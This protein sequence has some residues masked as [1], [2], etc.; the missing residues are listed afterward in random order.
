MVFCPAP[1]DRFR[2]RIRAS[3][4]AGSTVGDSQQVPPARRHLGRAGPARQA[5]PTGDPKRS[6]P[7]PR[8]HALT[9]G[10]GLW[11][12][13]TTK[14]WFSAILAEKWHGTLLSSH[15][16]VLV[17]SEVWSGVRRCFT[18]A[19]V[20]RSG[21]ECGDASP[22]LWSGLGFGLVWSAAVLHRR[23]GDSAFLL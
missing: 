21:L 11:V 6:A 17:W 14:H 10:A 8:H 22:P 15:L 13:G 3:F 7:V 4:R 9:L 12:D 2:G 20:F 23:F 5:G 1:R 16:S 19:L 18:A